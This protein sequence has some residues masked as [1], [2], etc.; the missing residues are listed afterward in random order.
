MPL[1]AHIYHQGGTVIRLHRCSDLHGDSGLAG[2]RSGLRPDGPVDAQQD[3]VHVLDQADN[4]MAQ[5]RNQVHLRGLRP[6]PDGEGRQAELEDYVI[7]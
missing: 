7:F 1:Y 6:S 5:P 3:P 4:Q 2:D